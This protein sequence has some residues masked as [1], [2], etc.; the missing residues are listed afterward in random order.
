MRGERGLQPGLVLV[1]RE[2]ALRQGLA[3]LIGGPL[4]IAIACANRRG[5]W[6]LVMPPPV[7]DLDSD[8][9]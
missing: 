1:H 5:G 2:V 4:P 8:K 9:F 6:R 7:L 3:Q